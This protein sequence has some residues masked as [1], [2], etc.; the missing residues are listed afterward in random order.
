VNR[1]NCPL[2]FYL[3]FAHID[4]L[5]K[6]HLFVADTRLNT[7]VLRHLARTSIASVP[8][9]MGYKGSKGNAFLRVR[10]YVKVAFVVPRGLGTVT[11]KAVLAVTREILQ[12]FT[13]EE[14]EQYADSG[15]EPP[16]VG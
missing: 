12:R 3:C 13:D 15:L 7:S 8:R 1:P 2:C 4:R 9:G 16:L 14:V 6:K 10:K 11:E 5:S